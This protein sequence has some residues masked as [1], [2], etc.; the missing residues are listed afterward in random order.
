MVYIVEACV[1]GADPKK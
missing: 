1:E